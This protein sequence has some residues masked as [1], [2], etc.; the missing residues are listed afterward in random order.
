VV[1]IFLNE[2]M[3]SEATVI[4]NNGL[5]G[6]AYGQDTEGDAPKVAQD[7]GLTRVEVWLDG[8]TPLLMNAMSQQQLLDIRDKKK[9][10]RNAAKP[11]VR[12]EADSKV[13]RLADGRPCVPV[14]C[15]YATLIGAGRFVRLD[16]KR[17]VSTAT[18]T[19]LPGM[20][21]IAD[22]ELPVY[23]LKCK[24]EVDIQQGRNPNG[25]EAVCVVRPRFDEWQLRMTIE[26]DQ[27]QMSLKM[28]R[29]LVEIA[30]R[31]QGLLDFRP[32]TRGTYGRWA[33]GRWQVIAD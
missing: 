26:V 27:G 25:G 3:M 9:A 1:R 2:V 21:T 16:G 32:A 33:I 31:R 11:S 4:E 22:V 15:V 14:K 12:E 7:G 24:W 19:V 18:S 13:Y 5:V 29:E 28:A 10:A 20:L 23:P 8:V 30:G 6:G 17:Q